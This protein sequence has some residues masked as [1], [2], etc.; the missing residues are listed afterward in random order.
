VLPIGGLK[1]KLL[2][3]KQAGVTTCIIPQKNA[4]DL[5][6]VPDEIK[7]G[8]DI[9]PVSSVEEVFKIALEL[10]DPDKFLM[11]GPNL[12]VLEGES[13]QQVAN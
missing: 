8:L 10:Q 1:E 13:S 9:Y 5:R 2:A 6:K 4:K 3:A 11:P 12:T 7:N